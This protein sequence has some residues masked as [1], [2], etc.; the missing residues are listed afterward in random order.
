MN[1]L[2]IVP[3]LESGGVETGTI[4]LALHL[5]KLGNNITVV[6]S[7]GVLAGILEQNGITHIKLPVHRKSISALFLVP[8]IK[9]ILKI[10]HIDI[11]HAS[12]RVPAWI[13]FLACKLTGTPF[14]TSCHGF[15]S[16]HALSRIMG[17]GKLVIVI[18][19][20]IKQRMVEAFNVPEEKTRLVYRGLDL[21]EYPYCPDKHAGGEDKFI[22]INIA[23]LTPI[24]G[25]REFIEAMERVLR[26]TKH[27]EA[28]IVGGVEAGKEYYLQQLKDL[29]QKLKIEKNIKFLG[30]R[31]DV[32]KLLKE[33][34]CL[35]LST[36]IPEGFG[37]VVIE[38]GAAGTPVCAADAGGVKEIVASGISGLLFPPKDPAKMAETIIKMAGDPA[39]RIKCA[40]NLRKKV[41]E[42][43]TV[44]KMARR[45]LAVYEEA[46]R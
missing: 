40:E 45:T 11:V 30:R 12:S 33:A 26:V 42:N 18:S 8:K 38:A 24:K 41:E 4:D 9:R 37:R 16:R 34:D 5:K 28:W 27:A 31:N 17:R 36:N 43:F 25:Q 3:A 19:E 39:F 44:E 2:H 35:V 29:A 7:G 22:I 20:S 21:A 46:L 10:H 6:S 32:L 23:R 14:V 15:Y 13:G 1:I